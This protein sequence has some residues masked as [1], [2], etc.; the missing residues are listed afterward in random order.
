MEQHKHGYIFRESD[1]DRVIS[2]YG[3]KPA[4]DKRMETLKSLQ[5]ERAKFHRLEQFRSQKQGRQRGMSL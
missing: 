3:N 4:N 5:K 1:V 2:Q